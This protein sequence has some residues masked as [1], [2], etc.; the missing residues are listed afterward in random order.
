MNLLKSI[1]PLV[2]L[3]FFNTVVGY[4]EKVDS[5]LLWQERAVAVLTNA[6]RMAPVTFRDRYIGNSTILLPEN[7]P[8]VPLA[9]MPSGLCF[10][11]H[12]YRGGV[13]ES[14]RLINYR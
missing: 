5:L 12:S 3:S 13:E 10:L 8:A 1:S 11:R 2:I 14:F 4:G 7:Y 9:L 6:C